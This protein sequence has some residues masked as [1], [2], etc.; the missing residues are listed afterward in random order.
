MEQAAVR[1]VVLHLDDNTTV[2]IEAKHVHGEIMY[3]KGYTNPADIGHK[4]EGRY[5]KHEVFWSEPPIDTPYRS[6]L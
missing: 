1:M 2:L 5:M 4:G 6:A 3:R